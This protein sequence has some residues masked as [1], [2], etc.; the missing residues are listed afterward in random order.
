MNSCFFYHFPFSSHPP[1][2]F[3]PDLISPPYPPHPPTSPPLSPP[4]KTQE[5]HAH[6]SISQKDGITYSPPEGGDAQAGVGGS[7][8]GAFFASAVAARPQLGGGFSCSP[9]F[10]VEWGERPCGF[11]W[12]WR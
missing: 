4:K 3:F 1:T 6:A 12:R 2:P 9:F 10:R 8:L 7:A 5:Q 11:D